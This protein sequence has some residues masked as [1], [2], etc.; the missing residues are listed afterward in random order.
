MSVPKALVTLAIGTGLHERWLQSCQPDWQRYAERHGY[1]LICITEPLD[2]SALARARSP[3]WQKCLVLSQSFSGHYERIVWVDADVLINPAAPDIVAATPAGKVGAVDEYSVPTREQYTTTLAKL[4]RYWDAIGFPFVRNPTPESFYAA[5]GFAHGFPQVVQTGV[6]V[7]SPAH[8]RGLLER[9]YTEYADRGH[10]WNYEMRPLSYEL[11]KADCVHW[12]DARFNYTWGI[13]QALHFPFLMGA[14]ADEHLAACLAEA[15]ART[16]F[17]HFAGDADLMATA[18]AA[19]PA[20]GAGPGAPRTSHSQKSAQR[21]GWRL[22]RTPVALF[23]FNRPAT[24]EKVFAAL[25]QVRPAR[26]LVVADG[27]RPDH[28]EDVAAC[29]AARAIVARIDWPCELLTDFAATNMGLKPRFDS[30]LDWVFAQCDEAIILE[31]DCVAEPTFFRFCQELLEQYRHDERVLSVSGD[32]FQFGLRRSP[33]SYYFSRYSHIWGWATWRRAW[34]LYDPAMAR[35]PAL[36]DA[37][38]LEHVLGDAQAVQYWSYI[39]QTNFETGETWDYA[40]L[41]ASWLQGGLHALPAVNLVA[42]HGFGPTAMHTR[43]VNSKFASMPTEPVAFPL[44]HPPA[45]AA[46]AEA[47]LFTE[48]IMFSGSLRQMFARVRRLQAARRAGMT[49]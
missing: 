3:A 43:A 12:L 42:N 33:A 26:L 39:F 35:W 16:Y 31:D 47:D 45:V 36:R 44:T 2:T 6:M 30:G 7:L 37:G 1:D 22:D 23:L 18:V 46:W 9:V 38:W 21:A 27:P 11:L 15:K 32:N 25:R 13:Y 40:W 29:A 48:E 5:F 34:S 20:T 14:K 8:H 17:L 4:Y 19:P 41:F 10:N 49:A 24:T 28:P